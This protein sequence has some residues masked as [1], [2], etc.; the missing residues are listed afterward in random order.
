MVLYIMYHLNE[1]LSTEASLCLE[2]IMANTGWDMVRV[3]IRK[4]N[5]LLLQ[6][7]AE[8]EAKQVTMESKEWAIIQTRERNKAE[9]NVR[10]LTPLI[11]DAS[12]RYRQAQKRADEE[13]QAN[14]AREERCHQTNLER[15]AENRRKD[16]MKHGQGHSRHLPPAGEDP[17]NQNATVSA[18]L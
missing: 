14:R 1:V 9:N 15:L 3:K 7:I 8:K 4:N 6:R 5:P 11:R 2:V 18:L 12:E 13:C 16:R 10:Q 17:L